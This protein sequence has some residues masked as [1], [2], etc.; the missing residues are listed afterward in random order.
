MY[1]EINDAIY[2]IEFDELYTIVYDESIVFEDIEDYEE[3]YIESDEEEADFDEE[4]IPLVECPEFD[5]TFD[6]A[7]A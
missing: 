3:E 4:F 7:E 2:E 6:L 5:D 1:A